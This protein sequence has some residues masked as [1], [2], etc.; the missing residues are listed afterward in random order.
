MKITLQRLLAFLALIA[1]SVGFGFGFDAVATAIEKKNHPRPESISAYISANARQFGIP[2]PI[3][4]ATVCQSSNFA[5]NAL[6]EDGAIGLMQI[7]PERYLEICEL[8]GE[9]PL[10]SG[11]LYDPETNLRLGTAYLSHLYR[12]YGV[13]DTVFA[14]YFA[15]TEA[16]EAWLADEETVT[17]MGTLQNLPRETERF[18][19]EMNDSVALYGKLY[20]EMK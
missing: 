15:G 10:D 3:L 16:T 12:R 20:Y 2:E 18:V 11:I 9:E 8:L 7:T 17:P 13:W 1:L 19:K 4:W 14:A 5:S 6:G